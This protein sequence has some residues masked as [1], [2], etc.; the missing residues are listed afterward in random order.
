MPPLPSPSQQQQQDHVVTG[1]YFFQQCCSE[2]IRGPASQSN[3][4]VNVPF[5]YNRLSRTYNGYVQTEPDKT[6]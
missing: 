5:K 1:K 6:A 2:F 4:T 3:D